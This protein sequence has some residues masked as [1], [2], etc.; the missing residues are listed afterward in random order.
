[1]LL[2]ASHTMAAAAPVPQVSNQTVGLQGGNHALLVSLK[3]PRLVFDCGTVGG[4]LPVQVS[5]SLAQGKRI[6]LRY[7]TQAIGTNGD[8]DVRLCLEWSATE[9][10][11]R[12]WAEFRLNNAP[13]PVL[14]KEVILEDI[15]LPGEKPQLEGGGVQS[16]PAFWSGFFA[17][18]EF[19]VAATRIEGERLLVAHRPGWTL[20]D[21]EWRQSRKAVFGV[22]PE[23]LERRQFTSYIT[24]HR[25]RPSGLHVNYNSWWTSPAPFYKESDILGLMDQFQRELF[26]PCGVSFDTFCI[27]MGWAE[28]RSV[29][30]IKRDLFPD[31]F[32]R[33]QAAAGKMGAS[34]GLWISPTACY[35]DALNPDWARTN[36][37][38]F[39]PSGA[40]RAGPRRCCL[41]GP[42]Y[43]AAFRTQLV[44][45]VQRYGIRHVKLDGYC[46]ECPEADHGHAP[47][48]LSAEAMAEGGIAAFIAVRQAQPDVWLESTCFGWNPSPW[49][50]FHV[51]SVIGTYGD[52]APRG[53]VPAPIYRESYTTAR[54][55]YNLQ[56]AARLPVPIV[57]QE[58][59][60]VIHQTPEPFLN[61]AVITAL[62]GN[63]FLPLYVN[64]AYMDAPRW[65]AL[66]QFL[67]WSRRNAK[68][69]EETVPILPSAWREGKVPR[70][71]NDAPMPREPYGYAHWKGGKGLVALRNPWI[72]PQHLALRLDD[73]L[74]AD[75]SMKHLNIVSLYP[76]PRL[77]ASGARFG[78]TL[79]IPLA[80]YETVV[81]SVAAQQQLRG[82]PKAT[83]VV[84]RKIVVGSPSWE[85]RRLKSGESTSGSPSDG[86][87]TI[88]SA[89]SALE[90][91]FSADVTV[92]S[93]TAELL[94]LTESPNPVPHPAQ[95]SLLV[96]G[97][98]VALTS[99]SS[100]KGWAAT[101]QPAREH[102]LFLNGPVPAGRH[103]VALKL[104]AEDAPLKLSAWLW[105]TKPGGDLPTYPNALPSPETVSL[106]AQPL[107]SPTDVQS[108]ATLFPAADAHADSIVN[109]A[110][111][112]RVVGREVSTNQPAF[113]GALYAEPKGLR[114]LGAYSASEDNGR[115]WKP[116]V[117]QPDLE[118]KL[119]YGYRR[120]PV[121]SVC[122]RRM[123]RLI[124]ILNAL[125]TP[126]LDPKL[127]EPA[128]AQ[129]TYYLRYRVS[130]DGGRTWLLD[131][132]I[133]QTGAF[134]STH[135]IEGVWVG[136]NAVYLGDA[137]CIPIVARDGRI[138]VPAQ[139]TPL[140]PDGTLWNPSG[141]H[142]FTEVVVLIGSWTKAGRLRW[143][144]S[145]RVCGDPACTTRGLIEPTLAE[146]P[147]G[148]ILMVMRGSNGGKADPQQQLPSYKWFSVSRDGGRTWSKAEPWTYDDGRPFFS[149][150]SMSTLFK[151]SSGRWFWVGNVATTNCSGNLPR[152]PLVVG[153]VNAKS[154]RLVRQSQLLLDAERTSD[155][156]QGR[157]DI[158]HVR[159]FED[160]QTHEIMLT[161]PRAH[162]AYKSKDWVT[163]RLALNSGADAMV[164]GGK[165]PAP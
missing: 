31:G 9:G 153:E 45:L 48:V 37:E 25:P 101:G 141:G 114:L 69:L 12:K 91:S 84:C 4:A 58:V 104:L 152:W 97:K 44:D 111:C 13:S 42:R 70:F 51:N 59:L 49:W 150:S 50:L 95:A 122:D 108:A 5:G 85:L 52:D 23:G 121:T 16:Y 145:E 99:S 74:G 162:Y 80:P 76:E 140:A 131:E 155:K 40:G 83:D 146:F 14:L 163:A 73:S 92:G 11:L 39:L 43:A 148:R 157:L 159:L 79:H 120:E 55:Y 64:P 149:P 35:P 117:F 1:L 127:T 90:L 139:T 123:G 109:R 158:S 21:G 26:K 63:A 134:N 130:K 61:D 100:A 6:E 87:A 137:G 165:P 147:D 126:G 17:G 113:Y 53:R 136:K 19:P 7:P 116:V 22:A 72:M 143:E 110:A 8:L 135:P 78:D 133:V 65:K 89:S 56:G 128:V 156:T 86:T 164:G 112:L 57:A 67:Q 24:A 20:H 30:Q 3:C 144:A 106:D 38:T 142:T 47:G 119:P 46:L 124:T 115:T 105:A 27:D 94:L 132:P 77:Y 129:N 34:L 15:E 41:G 103:R 18:I 60:G 151:H 71:S 102:W 54:D 10:L 68:L 82:L 81:L 75:R 33:I 160:R 62:R 88:R 161:Y 36:V 118:D 96:D 93:P 138:L 2:A 29:W 32:S 28:P 66:G 154:L 98:E 125:D 107:L